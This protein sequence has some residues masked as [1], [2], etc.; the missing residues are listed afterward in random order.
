MASVLHKSTLLVHLHLH[1]SR[2]KAWVIPP[3]G[4]VELDFV[5]LE[6]SEDQIM[7]EKDLK[8]LTSMLNQAW[9]CVHTDDNPASHSKCTHS[10]L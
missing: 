9:Q 3:K 6:K 10:L 1:S 7:P 2:G 4:I 8:L 5:H